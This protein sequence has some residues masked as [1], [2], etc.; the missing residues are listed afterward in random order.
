MIAIENAN[1]FEFYSSTSS[2]TMQGL[3]YECRNAGYV[4]IV[5]H[6]SWALMI[7]Q[8]SIDSHDQV[9]QLVNA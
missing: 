1:D 8:A 3:G 2:G 6:Q 4:T 7:S 9:H 5:D